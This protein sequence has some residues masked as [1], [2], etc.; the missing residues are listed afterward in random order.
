MSDLLLDYEP[1]IAPKVCDQEQRFKSA[2]LQ[3]IK[4][5]F[6]FMKLSHL[7]TCFHIFSSLRKDHCRVTSMDSSQK[8]PMVILSG[9]SHPEL[10]KLI[11]E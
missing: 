6:S 10:T 3:I 1:R 7:L 9:N 8:A 11:C 5:A 2:T 4:L